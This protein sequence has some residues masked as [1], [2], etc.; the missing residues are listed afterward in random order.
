MFGEP[1]RTIDDYLTICDGALGDGGEH[2]R[3]YLVG[4]DEFALIDT[5]SKGT[6]ESVV[7]EAIYS[8]GKK[9]SAVKYIFLTHYHPDTVGG[10]DKLRKTFPKAQIA[11][12]EK[13]AE[14]AKNPSNILKTKN[15]Q[16]GNKE[17]LY[18][19]VKRDIFDAIPKIEPDIL[20]K[21]GERF[22]LDDGKIMTINFDGHCE[23]HTMYFYTQGK[24]LFSGDA[25][26]MYPSLPHSYLIDFSGSYKDWLKNLDFLQKASTNILCPAHDQYQEG[27]SI[28]PYILDVEMAFKEKER[29]I[30][31]VMQ[32]QKFLTLDELT[33]RVESSLGVLW[34]HPY[35]VLASKANFYAHLE[36]LIIEK[37]VQ[38]N[39]KSKPITYTWIGPKEESWF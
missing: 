16:F 7:E 12:N 6:T 24:I 17:R 14:T 19:A 11:V 38:L 18:F 36:K 31:M 33:Q 21:D 22:D 9:L 39:S 25:L 32:E 2:N 35:N 29:Q 13:L 30:E 27:R 1:I 15:F 10:L 28:I 8:K 20:F 3:I 23:G 26:N 37:K 5:G 4:K 34:Y